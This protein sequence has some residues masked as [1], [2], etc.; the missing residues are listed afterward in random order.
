MTMWF[1]LTALIRLGNLPDILRP[2][3]AAEIEFS[4]FKMYGAALRIKG[5]LGVSP[6]SLFS[7]D[8]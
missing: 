7:T 8:G 4:W 2:D 3:N 5:G 1:V 6:Y